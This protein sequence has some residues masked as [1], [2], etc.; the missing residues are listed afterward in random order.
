[1]QR[2]DKNNISNLNLQNSSII[3]KKSYT[4]SISSNGFTGVLETDQNLTLEPFD[5]EDYNLTYVS[6]GSVESLT[7]QKVSVLNRTI[8]L[9]N[10][11]KNGSA[12]LTVTYRKANL[13]TKKKS[14]N[15]CSS[16]IVDGSSFVSSGTNVSIG[17][18]TLNDGLTYT[19][20]YGLRV[21]DKV[22]SLN[23]C[24]VVNI[25]GSI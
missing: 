7:S 1:M 12:V 14:F 11:S 21:H 4:V 20:I 2:L 19:Q 18:T 6:D 16:L 10:L 3:V 23:T 8:T 17:N 15:R 22:I 25:F 24:D 5:E 9:S 13:K